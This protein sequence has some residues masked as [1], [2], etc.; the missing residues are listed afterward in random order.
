M[1]E[2][3]AHKEPSARKEPSV[4]EEPLAGEETSVREWSH[5]KRNRLLQAADFDPAFK[6]TRFKVSCSHF[7]MLAAANDRPRARLGLVVPKKKVR[8]AVQRNRIK[9]LV[10]ERFRLSQKK[11]DMAGLD[12]VVLVGKGADGLSNQDVTL[13]VGRLLNALAGKQ[14][15]RRGS[16]AA[17]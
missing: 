10:R 7:L 6:Q 13:K 3:S 16:H 1:P 12:I 15:K 4:R 9:R 5:P 14:R 8:R 17:D 11:A 2:P